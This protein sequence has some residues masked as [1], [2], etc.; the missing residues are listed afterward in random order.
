MSDLE[1]LQRVVERL[2]KV[3]NVK[4]KDL[5]LTVLPRI[6]GEFRAAGL[7]T[8]EVED[9]MLVTGGEFALASRLVNACHPSLVQYPEEKF[10]KFIEVLK[11]YETMRSLAVEMESKFEQAGESLGNTLFA[12]H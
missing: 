11:G 7:I 9:S 6:A 12:A 1:D 5:I 2:L 3:N 4:L 10:P 8:K